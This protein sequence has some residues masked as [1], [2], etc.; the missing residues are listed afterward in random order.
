MEEEKVFLRSSDD[1]H[2]EGR[3]R[4]EVDVRH[5]WRCEYYN[6]VLKC[7]SVLSWFVITLRLRVS[8]ETECVKLINTFLEV[9]VQE[10]VKQFKVIT[11]KAKASSISS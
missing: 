1:K 5:P 6:K 10:Q 2:D 4:T 3:S 9:Q 8:G 7:N 11:N